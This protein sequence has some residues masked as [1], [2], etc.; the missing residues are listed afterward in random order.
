MAL[1]SPYVAP[2]TGSITPLITY[3]LTTLIPGLTSGSITP[4]TAQQY[5]TL[6]VP[7][8]PPIMDFYLNEDFFDCLKLYTRQNGG[9]QTIWNG[10]LSGSY[11]QGAPPLSGA[12]LQIQRCQYL[13]GYFAQVLVTPVISAFSVPAAFPPLITYLQDTL[14]PGLMDGSIPP[15]QAQQSLTGYIPCL[16][17]VAQLLLSIRHDGRNRA[18]H[19]PKRW[20][21]SN[22][23]WNVYGSVSKGIPPLE[24]ALLQIQRAQYLAGFL[25]QFINDP[26]VNPEIGPTMFRL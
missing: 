24:G 11:P 26:A 3:L 14:I 2:E 19:A 25:Y 16:L 21:R 17:G 23:E 10:V 4:E 9:D 12:A 7:T 6:Y 8:Y 20:Q 22:L 5:L 1:L 15:E 18:V 13:A